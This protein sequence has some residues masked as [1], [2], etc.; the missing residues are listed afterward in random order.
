MGSL[1]G[2]SEFKYNSE[3]IIIIIIIIIIILLQLLLLLLCF[4]ESDPLIDSCS[5]LT[6]RYWISSIKIASTK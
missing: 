3:F 4:Y 2:Q 6:S 1:G 5:E